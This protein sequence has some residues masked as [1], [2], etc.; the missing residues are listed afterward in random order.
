MANRITYNMCGGSNFTN[1][2]NIEGSA[3]SRNMYSESNSTGEN[4][5]NTK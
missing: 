5:E 3:I 2:P 4:D 1:V